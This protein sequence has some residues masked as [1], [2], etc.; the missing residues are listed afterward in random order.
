MIG[1]ETA[2]IGSAKP[3]TSDTVIPCNP[4]MQHYAIGKINTSHSSQRK[5]YCIL[6]SKWDDEAVRQH[7]CNKTILRSIWYRKE[8]QGYCLG[9][10]EPQEHAHVLENLRRLHHGNVSVQY[11]CSSFHFSEYLP[12]QDKCTCISIIKIPRNRIKQRLNKEN[13][14]NLSD[15]GIL[16]VS[17]R[18]NCFS[19]KLLYIINGHSLWQVVDDKPCFGHMKFWRLEHFRFSSS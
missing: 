8:Y 1:Q 6:E 2:Q 3:W 16:L 5:T 11:C 12:V 18:N 15:D 13:P 7:G 14:I 9:L 10:L 19:T 17:T 4:R